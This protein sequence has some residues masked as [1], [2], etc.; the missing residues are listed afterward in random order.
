[1]T[2]SRTLLF[3]DDHD[4]LYRPGTARRLRPLDR[5]PHNPVLPARDKPWEINIGWVG[6]AYDPA[7]GLYRLWYQAFTGPFARKRTHRCL[8]CYAESGDGIHWT[9]PDLD[10]FDYNGISPTNIVM[11][12]NGGYSDR[13]TNSVLLD[14]RDPDPGRRYKMAT[15]DFCIDEGIER[16]GLVVAFSPDGIHWT[17]H[18]KAPLLRTADGDHDL[19]PFVDEPGRVW[20]IPLALSDAM[21]AI[22]DPVRDRFVIY[23]KMWIDGP[24]GRTYWKHAMGRT[25][26]SD[27][28]HWSK[29]EL[30]LAPDELDPPWVEFHHSPAFYYQPEG[31][32]SSGCY[33]ALLQI[34]HRD[35]RGGIMDAELAISRDGLHWQ[36]PFRGSGSGPFFL[37][38]GAEGSFDCGSILTNAAPVFFQDE[39]RFYYG[40]YAEGATGGD[41]ITFKTGVGMASMPRDRF[42]ALHPYGEVGQVT[43]RPLGLTGCQSL[44]LNANAAAGSAQV[45]V[46]N[47]D[48]YRVRGFAREDA[49]PITGDGLRLPVRWR[50]SS[51]SE[52]RTLA[53]LP[54]GSYCLRIY[55][56]NAELYAATIA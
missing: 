15:Y 4:I 47:A 23:S 52:T 37:P 26:S 17:K 32:S 33:F 42:A 3:V 11:I 1:M 35:V 46:L 13:Y 50:R 24:D 36:R 53:D 12:G 21:D 44:T 31:A 55:L 56:Q 48:G 38:R 8:V 43:L 49:A 20:D 19:V 6:N 51:A 27:F 45:E 14:P 16:P 22:Y 30:V 18:P 39:L 54:A 2:A 29:P 5:C 7:T 41:D 9:K 25:E 10:L 28:I 40:G 34:L